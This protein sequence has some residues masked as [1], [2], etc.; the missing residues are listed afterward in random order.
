VFGRPKLSV[1]CFSGIRSQ[2]SHISMRGFPSF[3]SITGTYCCE[4]A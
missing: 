1:V 4:G 2:E 3:Q